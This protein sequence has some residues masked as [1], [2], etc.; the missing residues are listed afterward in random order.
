MK[1]IVV[2]GGGTGG[3]LFPAIALAE[4]LLLRNYKM[5]LITDTKCVSFLNLK[6]NFQIYTIKFFLG[7]EGFINKIFSI[8]LILLSFTKVLK[9]FLQVKPSLV[10]CFG[11]Y[12][13]IPAI[14]VAII[15][16]IPIVLHEQN[17]VLGRTNK[18]FLRFVK[19]IALSYDNTKSICNISEK[20]IVFTGGI[21]RKNINFLPK[22][23][24]D[25]NSFKILVLGGSQGAK[26]FNTLI[27][28]AIKEIK[29][30]NPKINIEITQQ[31]SIKDQ[32]KV[33]D[34]YSKLGVKANLSAFFYDIQDLYC[35]HDLIIS[36]AGASTIS[37]L[38]N[39]GI[40]AILIPYPY[41]IDNHQFLNAKILA[42]MQASW[43]FNQ[44]QITPLI[45]ANK[46]ITLMENPSLLKD[47]SKNILQLKKDGVKILS[48]LVDTLLK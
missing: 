8:P 27:P 33:I 41:A 26:V 16:R 13:S 45:L 34:F 7:K 48:D 25:N 30:L 28:F 29:R 20:K 42:D 10:I 2:I 5:Y 36:R 14:I 46:I 11:S 3:H 40:A 32:L 12:F 4:E 38:I 47:A 43:C 44:D 6:Y 22:I 23:N 21:V 9:L 37:E 39:A 24:N 15:L 18:F 1:K 19:K 17:C 31:V 35:R